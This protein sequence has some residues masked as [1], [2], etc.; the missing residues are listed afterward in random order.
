MAQT[1]KTFSGVA[2]SCIVSQLDPQN[3]N[4]KAILSQKISDLF[5]STPQGL[6]FC[7]RAKALGYN[8][9]ELKREKQALKSLKSCLEKLA[10]SKQDKALVDKVYSSYHQDINA[11]PEANR[12]SHIVEFLTQKRC[13]SEAVIEG[14]TRLKTQSVAIETEVAKAKSEYNSEL[15]K[16]FLAWKLPLTA[17]KEDEIKN[18]KANKAKYARNSSEFKALSVQIADIRKSIPNVLAVALTSSDLPAA[19]KENYGLRIERDII[20]TSATRLSRAPQICLLHCKNILDEVFTSAVSE[21]VGKLLSTTCD[22]S[23]VSED[24]LVSANRAQTPLSCIIS[25]LLQVYKSVPFDSANAEL[26]ELRNVVQVYAK[27]KFGKHRSIKIPFTPRV[28]ELLAQCLYRFLVC[29]CDNVKTRLAGDHVR[30]VKDEFIQD[31]LKLH[32]SVFDLQVP[33]YAKKPRSL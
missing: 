9:K 23:A 6:A 10:S 20:K 1:K 27:T 17:A 14:L 22:S 8:P 11:V 4:N 31:S 19:I 28:F 32:Y 18:I 29:L 26:C 7:E 24:M 21:Y 25:P 12:V 13:E 2:K 30:T 16:S 5:N 15:K 3:Y 33:T